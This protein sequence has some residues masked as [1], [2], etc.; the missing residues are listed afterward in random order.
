M[1]FEKDNT[2]RPF[3]VLCLDGGG[4]KGMYQASYL[5]QLGKVTGN[6]D[7]GKFFDIIAGTSTG[8]I[9][10][11]G[12]GKGVS[13]KKMRNL[14]ELYGANIF[15]YQYLRSLPIIGHFFASWG[16][17]K[18][19]KVLKEALMKVDSLDDTKIG[20]VYSERSISL[21]IP[22]INLDTGHP[23]VFKPSHLKRLTGLHDQYAL[24]DISLATSAA[25]IFRSI[26]P[27]KLDETLD[28]TPHIDGGLWANNPCA[29]AMVEALEIL[30][31][32]KQVGRP[33]NLYMLGCPQ[34][35]KGENLRSSRAY[36]RGILG[37]KAGVKPISL[38]LNAQSVGYEY[39][40]SKLA[41]FIG[42]GSF[43]K[44]FPND[45]IGGYLQNN[46]SRLDDARPKTLSKLREQ[47]IR[48]VNYLKGQASNSGNELWKELFEGLS[49]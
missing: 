25:P 6:D 24:A 36:N 27:I 9:I 30:H 5:E 49:K 4:M 13:P 35:S 22:S 33:I 12:L 17:G 47:A 11:C 45:Q 40:A 3:R 14:Y 2:D 42:D 26:A 15:P 23:V 46:L 16:I 29:A 44:R 20:E 21:V 39:I 37:W 18:G 8:G 34:P 32:K 48:D 1:S 38:S 28:E 10:A 43:A 19:A 41:G 7:I 31:D